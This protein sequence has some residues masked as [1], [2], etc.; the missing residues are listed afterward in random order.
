MASPIRRTVNPLAG[1]GTA[2]DMVGK[3]QGLDKT[4]ASA[5][6]ALNGL[7]GADDGQ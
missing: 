4:L 7:F 2:M 1:M 5:M 6:P 3:M